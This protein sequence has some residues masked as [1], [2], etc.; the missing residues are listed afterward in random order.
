MF[1][2]ISKVLSALLWPST[3]VTLVIC[4]GALLLLTGRLPRLA[5]RLVAGGTLLL[6]VL[7]FAPVGNWMTLPLE[8]RFPRGELPAEVAGILIL[9]GFEVTSVS[10]AR[11]QLA[12]NES[13]ERLTEALLVARQRPKALVIFTGGDG[14]LR[15]AGGSAAGA[16]G[17]FLEG[18]GIEPARL[19]LEARS[20]TTHE[21]ALFV[22]EMVAPKPGQRYVLVTSAFHMPRSVG[23]F[24]R[25]GFDVVPWP[26]DYRTAG[27][28]DA[29]DTFGSMVS[30]LQ[31]VD[32]AAKEWA[33]LVAYWLAGR[34][35]ALWPAP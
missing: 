9:G 33:G 13:A 18:A 2:Y 8:Q 12:L 1:F 35:S 27:P 26:V 32:L 22:K 17:R 31:Y 19:V 14:S 23:V 11:G 15:G 29:L 24:R 5:K 25:Q 16:V 34:T 6:L 7:G 30:G 10:A 3:V 28:S 20:R 4:A 21:N